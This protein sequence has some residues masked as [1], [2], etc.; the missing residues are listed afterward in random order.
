MGKIAGEMFRKLTPEEL[1]K[2]NDLAKK[3]HERYD[4]EK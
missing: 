4:K 2:Y 3:D 1:E